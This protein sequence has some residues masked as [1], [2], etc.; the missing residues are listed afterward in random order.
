MSP[1]GGAKY[2]AGPGKPIHGWLQRR[3][4]AAAVGAIGGD[5][6]LGFSVIDPGTQYFLTR[7]RMRNVLLL[8]SL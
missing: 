2:R 5:H 8:A 4:L 7:G 6:E 1:G 3:G